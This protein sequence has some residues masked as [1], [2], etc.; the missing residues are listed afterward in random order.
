VADLMDVRV[1]DA[2]ID[3]VC[4]KSSFDYMKQIDDK[5][6]AWELVPWKK[7]AAPMMRKGTQGSSSDLLSLEQQQR[8]DRHFI[9]ELKRLGSDF[10]YA[11]FCDLTPGVSAVA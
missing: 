4:N 3:R 11:E 5:F 1:A 10:P 8:L 7:T 9:S 6:R 2:I